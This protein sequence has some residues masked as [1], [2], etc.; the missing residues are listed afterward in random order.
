MNF[1]LLGY[2]HWGKKLAPILEKRGEVE[3]L[4]PK[5]STSTSSLEDIFTTKKIT[6]TFIA[7]PEETHYD[8]Y[9]KSLE[10][11]LHTFVEKPLCLE[12]HQALTLTELAEKKRKTLFVDYTFLYDP[13]IDLIMKLLQDDTIGGLQHISSI[14]CS[15]DIH[16]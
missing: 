3:I 10:Q 6:H 4:D 15:V 13:G 14:R 1:L 8:L 12:H 11:P 16:K 5:Y 9:L 2:G 7:S